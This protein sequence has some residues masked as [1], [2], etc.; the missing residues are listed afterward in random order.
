VTIC[1]V[2]KHSTPT[3]SSYYI[4]WPTPGLINTYFRMI[5]MLACTLILYSFPGLQFSMVCLVVQLFS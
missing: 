4:K 2:G 1:L 5:T 3:K